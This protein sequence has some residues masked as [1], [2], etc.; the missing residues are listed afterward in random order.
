MTTCFHSKWPNY[1]LD[2]H[3]FDMF[4]RLLIRSMWQFRE[5]CCFAAFSSYGF[6]LPKYNENTSETAA[7]SPSS[8][9]LNTKISHQSI[10]PT[11]RL[12]LLGACLIL[13]LIFIAQLKQIKPLIVTRQQVTVFLT[14]AR[15]KFSKVLQFVKD[16][17]LAKLFFFIIAAMGYAAIQLSQCRI[18]NCLV[19]PS[20]FLHRKSLLKIGFSVL[21][22]DLTRAK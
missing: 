4:M 11:N 22:W 5:L 19:K 21:P 16:E 1:S 17:W 2:M 8:S 20:A 10:L 7:R 13:I 15:R 14:N 9:T 6:Q 18:M 12:A 3:H